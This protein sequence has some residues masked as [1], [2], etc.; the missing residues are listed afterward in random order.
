MQSKNFVP[1]HNYY[2]HL[3]IYR[4][5]HDQYPYFLI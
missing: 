4:A 5:L 2:Y 3:H 1:A